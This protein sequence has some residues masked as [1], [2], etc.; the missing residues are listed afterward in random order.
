MFHTAVALSVHESA[1]DKVL[2]PEWLADACSSRLKNNE[3][4][5]QLW[6]IHIV[7]RVSLIEVRT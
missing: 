2:E 7:R 5:M 6:S 4:V 3:I 1:A